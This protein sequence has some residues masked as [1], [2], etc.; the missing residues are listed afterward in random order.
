ML[1]YLST[2][3]PSPL[4]GLMFAFLMPLIPLDSPGNNTLP[5]F[6]YRSLPPSGY[7]ARC[8]VNISNNL[9]HSHR[10]FF[11]NRGS[12]GIFGQLA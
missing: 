10:T 1:V 4:A 7:E 5:F 11:S 2:T 12:L 9:L 3:L 8:I 6:Y